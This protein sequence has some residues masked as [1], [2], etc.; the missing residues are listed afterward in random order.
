MNSLATAPVVVDVATRAK[1]FDLRRQ[2]TIER[3]RLRALQPMLETVAHRI[4]GV[5]TA[6]LR[7]AVRTEITSLDQSSWE[8]YAASVPEQTFV[9]SAVLLPL[10]GRAVLHLPVPLMLL[11]VDYYLG[12]DGLNQPER[13]ALTD[14]ERNLVNALVEGVWAE[15]PQP[16]GTFISLSPGMIGTAASA[17]LLQ[18]GRP[19]VLCLIVR[20]TVQI[21]DHEPVNAELCFP[22]NVVTALIEALERHQNR[23]GAAAVDQ[24]D[25]RRRLLGVPVEMKVSYPP[26]G[27]RPAELLTLNVGDVIHL[28]SFDLGRP[29]ELDLSVGDVHYGTGLLMETG[30]KLSCTVVT[31]KE[32]NDDDE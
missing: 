30:N 27:L 5:L 18:V 10:D 3:A 1:P 31:K 20:M 7:Q 15:I 28:G 32:S 6:S 4:G 2:E 22:V 9:S 8:D 21:G 19:G 26:L 16:F 17:L 12:G 23:A 29:H 24:R 13:N 11:A 25:A 14:M